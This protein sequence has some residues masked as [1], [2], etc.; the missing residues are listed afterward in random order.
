VLSKKE[1][2]VQPMWT[3]VHVSHG[4]DPHSAEMMSAMAAADPD[5]EFLDLGLGLLRAPVPIH[6]APRASHR[7]HWGPWED[8]AAKN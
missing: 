4:R 8:A 3:P 5:P 1:R 6:R 2:L 7:S